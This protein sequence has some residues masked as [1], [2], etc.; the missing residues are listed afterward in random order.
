MAG[1]LDVTDITMGSYVLTASTPL[2]NIQSVYHK[3]QEKIPTT[4]AQCAHIAP[5][6]WL[7]NNLPVL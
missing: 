1:L 5:R 6:T 2:V 3:I 7:K 4:N